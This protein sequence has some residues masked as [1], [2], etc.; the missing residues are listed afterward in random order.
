MS[1][2]VRQIYCDYWFIVTAGSC[3]LFLY[4]VDSGPFGGRRQDNNTL[5][6]SGEYNDNL[7]DMSDGASS[8]SSF[9]SILQVHQVAVAAIV[10]VVMRRQVV[11][12][13][14]SKTILSPEVMTVNDI[15]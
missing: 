4:V 12:A 9:A 5:P 8:L 11:V 3:T 1:P 14:A 15:E 7:A 10:T 2:P 6:A 13:A